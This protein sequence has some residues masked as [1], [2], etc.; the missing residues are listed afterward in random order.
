LTPRRNRA[1]R[2]ARVHRPGDPP[3][4]ILTL[5]EEG[6]SRHKQA[7]CC[8]DGLVRSEISHLARPARLKP[9]LP[10]EAEHLLGTAAGCL[11]EADYG[12]GVT[13]DRVTGGSCEN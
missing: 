2:A 3:A 6:R 5:S 1:Q 9:R 11:I 12:I 8:T 10:L 4:H 13:R 7:V